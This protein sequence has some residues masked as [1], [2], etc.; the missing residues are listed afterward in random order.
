MIIINIKSIIIYFEK[1][2]CLFFIISL[3]QKKYFFNKNNSEY[4]VSKYI[5]HYRKNNISQLFYKDFEKQIPFINTY[6]KLLRNNFIIDNNFYSQIIN[7][8]ITFIATVFNKEKYLKPFIYSIKNQLLKQF[9]IIMVDDNSK[10]KSIQL[11]KDFIKKD[12]RIKLI[13][14]KNN[15]GSLYARSIGAFHA[16]GKYI[17]FV[18]SDDIILKN[19]IE[20]AYNYINNN[21]LDMIQF[22]SVFELKRKVFISRRYYKYLNIIYQPVL[23]NIFYY[24]NKNGCE[25]NTALWDK[26]IKRD[27]VLKSLKFIGN[28]YLK[29]KIIIE[30]DV[31]LLFSL[32]QICKSYKYIDEIVYYYVISNNDSITNTKYKPEKADEI[33]HSIFTNINFLYEKTENS[34]FG[35]YLCI[36]KLYQGWNRYKKYFKYLKNEFNLIEKV[37][38]KLLISKFISR[39]D[40]LL[41]SSYKSDL[42]N[43]KKIKT[44]STLL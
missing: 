10:D 39:K 9:E 4:Y 22:H 32:F 25:K 5:K 44:N 27:T 23:S 29:D 19:G 31:I 34:Y 3:I 15:R 36:F 16:K 11:I 42:I 7:P 24:E 37:L 6:V 40:K 2:L 13:Q 20:I 43:Y 38:N 12:K 41:I 14:N 21:N 17:I 35:K 18:D 26:L 28:K 33:L 8:K 30:N 1:L